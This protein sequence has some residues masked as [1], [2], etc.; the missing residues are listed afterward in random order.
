[1]NGGD[2]QDAALF[3]GPELLG[4]EPELL[5]AEEAI[6]VVLAVAFGNRRV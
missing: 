6:M 4:K 1:M 3:V 5:L 2:A